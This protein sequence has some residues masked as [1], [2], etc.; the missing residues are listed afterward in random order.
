MIN[1]ELLK[2]IAR[3]GS[4]KFQRSLCVAGTRARYCVLDELIE[5][6]LDAA[7]NKATH[8][9]LSKTLLPSERDALLAFHSRVDQLFD[10]IPWSD[11]ETTIEDI[12]NDNDAMSGIRDAAD[13]CLRSVGARFSAEELIAG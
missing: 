4:Q 9:V 12:V 13:K 3:I 7:K 6:T 1:P 2:D 5:M 8:P 11:D 10:Q